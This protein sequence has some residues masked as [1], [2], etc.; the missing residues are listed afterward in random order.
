MSRAS[1]AGPSRASS[2]AIGGYTSTTFTPLPRSLLSGTGYRFSPT[3]PPEPPLDVEMDGRPASGPSTALLG[4]NE[5]AMEPGEIQE[6]SF[7]ADIFIDE[8]PKISP[9]LPNTA[10]AESSKS[11]DHF[12]PPGLFSTSLMTTVNSSKD[13]LSVELH[14]PPVL[15]D[16]K[17]NGKSKGKGKV[18]DGIEVDP[19][20]LLPSHVL[21][22]STSPTKRDHIEG[23]E[24]GVSED[25]DQM[26]GLYFVDDDISKGSKRYFDPEQDESKEVEATFLATADQSKICQNC[27]RPGHR[28]KDCKHVI[29]TT[30]GAED[31]HERR[32]CPV[33]LV[34][35]GCGG[36]GHR[37]QDCP[38]PTTRMSKRT[39]CDRCGSRD[40]MENTCHTIWRVYSYFSTEVRSEIQRDKLNAEG[41]EKEAI[42]GRSSDEW[43]YN[44]GKE[45]HLGDDCQKR[46]GSLARLT[47]PSAFSYEMASRG[48][49]FTTTLQSSSSSK[50]NNADLPPPTHSRFEDNDNG[51]QDDY[52]NL[53]FISGGYKNFGGS[54]AGKKTREKEKEKLRQL[55]RN[56]NGLSDEDDED[57]GPN[58]F[59]NSNNNNSNRGG[60]L[61]IRGRGDRGFRGS[62]GRRI[63][64]NG[65][66]NGN[67]YST[68][69]SRNNNNFAKKPWDS[70]YR[71]RDRNPN[72]HRGRNG[73]GNARE[74]SRSPPPSTSRRNDNRGM[75]FSHGYLMDS[76]LPIPSSAPAKVIS[77]GKLS[78]PGSNR[79]SNTHNTRSHGTASAMGGAK[80]LINRALGNNNS[81][82]KGGAG[83]GGQS[84]PSRTRGG[85]HNNSPLVKTPS[86]NINN[87]NNN[88]IPI[89]EIPSSRKKNK[90][91]N[92][93]Q[94]QQDK[95]WESEWRRSGGGGGKVDQWSKELDKRE[96]EL[97]IK[98][99][100]GEL[101]AATGGRITS[102]TPKS[103]PKGGSGKGKGNTGQRY[104]GGYD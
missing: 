58:W 10:E 42:G 17:G 51:D 99:R 14:N 91:K 29:C 98:G 76:S 34:C 18:N 94:N 33:G 2:P 19:E 22:D 72:G 23:N 37:K 5:N 96:K 47:V 87:N 70:E 60:G 39:G 84:T 16:G 55:S 104:H 75:P 89:V 32:D 88:N 30:C 54:N 95:D 21:V 100:S 78:E 63:D 81:T 93:N 53:P 46:R 59:K 24:G 43:C 45:G 97:K 1:T 71:E 102:T 40:H 73:N 64:D 38:D 65:N 82:P 79:N 27:K 56:K 57:D 74:R 7:G 49:F 103:G 11:N 52:D 68:P 28:S 4:D 12:Q 77:F 67:G 90:S 15:G 35:F 44:C 62:G 31:A 8:I 92:Q 61:N 50:R 41:W 3:P 83:D 48:P 26:E 20:L 85:K 66:G 69:N 36:R 101:N 9:P 80:A 6:S 86:S 13:S 25:E